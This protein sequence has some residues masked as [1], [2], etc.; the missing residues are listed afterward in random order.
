MVWAA[1]RRLPEREALRVLTDCAKDTDAYVARWAMDMLAR[2]HPA[3]A[4]AALGAIAEEGGDLGYSA[5]VRLIVIE[6]CTD[7]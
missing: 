7:R 1:L 5:A 2:E 4:A 6:C 3:Q